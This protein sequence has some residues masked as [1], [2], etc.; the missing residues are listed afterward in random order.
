M[1]VEVSF[2]HWLQVRRKALD[3]TRG[4]L[5]QKIGY[6]VSAL[7]KIEKDERRPSKQLV[8]ILADALELSESER[9]LFMKVARGERSVDQLTTLPT[10]PDLGLLQSSQTLSSSIPT[11]LTPLI[12]RETELSALRQMLNDPQCRLIT[13]V[14]P[15]GIGKTRL[16]IEFA[17]T[18]REAFDDGVCFVSLAGV[19]NAEFLVLTLAESLHFTFAGALDPREQLLTHLKQKTILLVLDNFEHLLDGADLLAEI[20]Q[21]TLGVKLLVTS[22][23]RLNL[24]GEWVIE[25]HGLQL[26]STTAED[27]FSYSAATLFVQSAR[28]VSINSVS[29]AEDG[30]AVARI[31]H[32]MEGMPLGIELAASW[33]RMLSCQEIAQEVERSLD[34]LTAPVHGTPDRHHSM[35]A[36]FDHS[37]NLLSEAERSVL[38]KLSIFRGGFQR[39]AAEQVAGASLSLLS[40][41]MD[42]SLLRRTRTGRYEIHELLRQYAEVKQSERSGEL[43]DA[44]H[45]YSVYYGD[46]AQ[47]LHYELVGVH[48]AEDLAEASVEMDNIRA[49]WQYA[50]NHELV[51]IVQKF[52]SYLWHFYEIRGWFK[53]GYATFQWAEENMKN[54]SGATEKVE[55]EIAILRADLR[56][57]YAWFCLRL[58]QWGEASRLTQESVVQLRSLGAWNELAEV[59]HLAGVALWGTGQYAEA[60]VLLEEKIALDEKLGNRWDL[61]MGTG[62]LGL[63]YQGLGDYRQARELMRTAQGLIEECGDQ[64]MAAVSF[65]HRAG[66]EFDLGEMD[67]ARE[68]LEKSLALSTVVGDRWT[69]GTSRFQLGLVAQ[70]QGEHKQA[71]R[72]FHEA[73][74]FSRETG[75]HWSKVRTLNGLGTSMLALGDNNGAGQAYREALSAAVES[76]MWPHALEA[77]V[78]FSNW[79]TKRGRLEAALE[80]LDHVVRHPVCS[81]HI[82]EH[83][84]HLRAEIEAQLTTRQIEDTLVQAR[85]SDFESVVKEILV[86]T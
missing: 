47:R 23:E 35:R 50:V 4:E 77:L 21:Q 22:R 9:P 24:R 44:W 8:E 75:E 2:G 1:E 65:F 3:L 56:A 53:E 61:A 76:E 38:H 62:Q 70:A 17:G 20:L 79:Q 64:R 10:L 6:S 80:T 34:F 45:R 49:A 63:V 41:L 33:V 16:A 51:A 60:R 78:G 42:K 19:K 71:L 69:M 48:Q 81:Q 12:G 67:A 40:A 82:S 72:W 58:G 28:R 27:I 7:R 14:G 52:V 83:A 85:A 59:L 30:P 84:N 15:G 37:W 46:V 43:E 32:L 55:P 31:C 25:L 13:L 39:E 26:P 74:E 86:A 11:P 68:L 18:Q 54:W 66:V 73:L 57:H 5:A 36:V 29:I